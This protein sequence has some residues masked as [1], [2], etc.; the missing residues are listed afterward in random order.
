M[1]IFGYLMIL[2][3][4]QLFAFGSQIQRGN[5]ALVPAAFLK[6][7]GED[8]L[9]MFCRYFGN[10]LLLLAIIAGICAWLSLTAAQTT[11]TPVILFGA[12]FVLA[13][14]LIM[15]DTKRFSR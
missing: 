8:H 4:I 2:M 12:G 15:L 7:I 1:K 6:N 9:P 14:I 3:V 5:A 11:M 10:R 13:L